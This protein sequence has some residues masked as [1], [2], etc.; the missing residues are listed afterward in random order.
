MLGCRDVALQRLYKDF[1]I[2]QNYFSYRNQQRPLMKVF[3]FTSA[4][5]AQ[6]FTSD[7]HFG[8]AGFTKLL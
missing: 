5:I 8:Q 2:T 3:V 4:W 7:R 6:A 1:E